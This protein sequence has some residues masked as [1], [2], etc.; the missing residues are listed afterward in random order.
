MAPLPANNTARAW[1]E[2]SDGVNQHVLMTR[3]DAS[4]LSVADA[5]GFV[6]EFLADIDDFLY[7]IEIGGARWAEEGS[8][9]SVPVT[10]PG[11]TTHGTDPMP[12]LLAPRET[13][14]VGRDS[15]GRKVSFSLYGCK[16]TSPD[17]Y[18]IIS[19]GAN[20][21][22]LGVLAINLASA[23]GTF[24]TIGGNRATMKNYVDVNF[25]SYWERAARP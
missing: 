14:W 5:L 6:E 22:N 16:Y 17:I 20:L 12:V 19:S 11:A 3:F 10:W 4:A 1:T 18:R 21:Q 25:N 24:I 23:A 8:D 9:I 7:E 13:R 15:S 2:Y